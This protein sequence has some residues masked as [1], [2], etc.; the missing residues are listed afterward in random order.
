MIEQKQFGIDEM[1]IEIN[2]VGQH[3][4]A[5]RKVVRFG[6]AGLAAVNRH[7]NY[8]EINGASLG[9]RSRSRPASVGTALC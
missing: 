9:D 1:F 6:P 4:G 3:N 2:F 5:H 7:R 8:T